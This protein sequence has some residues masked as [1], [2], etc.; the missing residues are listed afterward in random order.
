MLFHF[1]CFWFLYYYQLLLSETLPFADTK[2]NK[3]QCV[4]IDFLFLIG[5]P[6]ENIWSDFAT[7]PATQNFTLKEQPYNN[8]K[9]KFPKLSTSGQ[10]LLNFLFMYDPKR[11]ATASE[12]LQSTY[13]KEQPFRKF[14]KIFFYING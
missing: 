10:R 2:E 3:Y 1:S 5:T 14:L 9:A 11:R 6:N 4:L 7:L 13:F 12:C 8:L